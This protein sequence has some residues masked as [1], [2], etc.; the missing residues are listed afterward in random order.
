[1]ET[2]FIG[3]I[4]RTRRFARADPS[5]RSPIS[6]P[7]V[8]SRSP[9]ASHLPAHIRPRPAFA[10]TV[11][12]D[13]AASPVIRERSLTLPKCHPLPRRSALY[14][15]VRLCLPSLCRSTSLH[16]ELACRSVRLA[17]K[18]L[19]AL[20]EQEVDEFFA[21]LRHRSGGTYERCKIALPEPAAWCPEH[22]QFI[23]CLHVKATELG[24]ES[25]FHEGH[26]M[27]WTK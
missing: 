22:L 14:P 21:D 13:R 24:F 17:M 10:I 11:S 9:C 19:K 12:P 7:L 5:M 25:A 23:G 20:Q 26:L 27:W 15:F 1:M 6:L 18:R 4:D 3:S 8:R 16:P 2:I